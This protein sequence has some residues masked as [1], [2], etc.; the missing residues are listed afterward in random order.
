[1]ISSNSWGA[2]SYLYSDS[3]YEIDDYIADHP[4]FVALFAAGNDGQL[5]Y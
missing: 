3:S 1:M 5:S 4:D 2:D